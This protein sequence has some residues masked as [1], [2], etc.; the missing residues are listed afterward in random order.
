LSFGSYLQP[1]VRGVGTQLTGPGADPNVAIYLDGVYQPSQLGNVTD[2]ANVAQVE[3]LKGPQGT[4]FGR[5]ATGGAF[6]IETKAPSFDPNAELTLTYGRY[7]E[8]KASGFASTGLSDNVATSLAGY[9]RRSDGWIHDIRTGSPR[10]KQ[11]SADIRSKTLFEP[12]DKLNVTLNLG[13]NEVSDPTGNAF[14][15]L[16]GNTVGNL[17]VPPAQPDPGPIATKRTE[18]S[19]NLPPA[20]QANVHSASVKAVLDLGGANLS[21]VSAYR[22]ERAFIQSDSEASYAG[23]VGGYL[24]GSYSQ[25]AYHQFFNDYSEELGSGLID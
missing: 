4:L 6:L 14:V 10:N 11:H 2:L 7:N 21:S 5:N 3:I 1:T 22:R 18:L 20:I 12:T 16:N 15:A 8:A 9:Y 25:N 17:N 13:Y 19:H 24:P 23:P